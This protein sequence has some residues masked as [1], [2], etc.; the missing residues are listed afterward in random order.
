MREPVSANNEHES[1]IYWI[2]EIIIG[3]TGVVALLCAAKKNILRAFQGT[4]HEKLAAPGMQ[5]LQ[6]VRPRSEVGVSARPRSEVGLSQQGTH[7]ERAANPGR[8]CGMDTEDLCDED[9]VA[10][11]AKTAS[12]KKYPKSPNASSTRKPDREEK[13]K[14]LTSNH[15]PLDGFD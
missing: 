1:S 13:K 4:A 15:I 5:E 10:E 8:R 2:Q 14:L 3:I 12:K 9:V 11:R 6:G 7:S